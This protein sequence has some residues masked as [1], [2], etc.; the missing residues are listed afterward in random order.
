MGRELLTPDEV[1]MLDNR[2][3]L[4]FIRGE[5]PVRDFKYN[6]LRHPNVKLTTDGGTALYRHGED[7]RSFAAI[8]LVSNDEQGVELDV[9]PC[10]FLLL[11]EAELEE[12][13]K[14]LEEQ[15][16]AKQEAKQGL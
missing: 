12:K 3:A 1:R 16:N 11:T 15:Q 9:E 13:L 14:E 10:D 2:Y 6:I 7:S 8:Q 5:R 4:L